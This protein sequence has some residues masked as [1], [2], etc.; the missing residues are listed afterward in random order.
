VL[1]YTHDTFLENRKMVIHSVVGE[2]WC[3]EVE[4]RKKIISKYSKNKS[5]CH[6]SAHYHITKQNYL[7]HLYRFYENMIKDVLSY[8]S[9]QIIVQIEG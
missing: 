4:G 2:I 8:L 6:S 1:V 5:F 9:S 3:Q 7:N